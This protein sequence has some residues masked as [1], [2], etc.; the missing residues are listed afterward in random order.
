MLFVTLLCAPCHSVAEEIARAMQL[1]VIINDTPTQLIGA[2]VMRDDGRIATRRQELEEIGFNPRGYASPDQLVALDELPGLSYRYDEPTQRIFITA[3]DEL[4]ARKEYKIINKQ[5]DAA[6][7]QSD[8]GSVLNYSVFSS[9]DSRLKARSFTFNGTSATL[10][11]RAFTPF[12]TF[13]QSGI[14]RTSL[15]DRFDALRLNTSVAYSDHDSLTTYSAGDTINSGLAWTRPI[16]MGG[17]QVARN[18]GLRPDLITLPLPAAEGSAAVPSTADVYINNIKTFSQ[19]VGTGPYRLS[20]LPAVAGS[21]MARVILR[22]ASGRETETN[23]PFYASAA[24]LAPGLFDYSV[25]AG[26]PRLSYG[27]ASDRYIAKPVASGSLRYGVFDWLTL[28]A[29]VE[30]GAGL[31]NGSSGIVARTGSFGVASFAVAA[32]QYEKGTGFQTYLSYETKLLGINISASSQLTFGAYDDL[33]SV[34]AR[35][36][37]GPA[38]P[39]GLGSLLDLSASVNAAASSLFTTARAPKALNRLSLGVPLPFDRASLSATFIQTTDAVGNRSSIASLTLTAGLPYETSFF[40]TA[41]MTLAGEKN[42]GFLAG[43]SLPLGNSVTASTSVSNGPGGTSINFDAAK[44]LDLKPGSVGWRLR[45]SEGGAAQRSAAMSY[46]SSFA[47]AEIGASQDRNGA[48]VTADIEG[49][50][51]TMGGGVFFAN[52]I[53]DAFAVVET[54]APGVEVFHENRSVGVT[55]SAGRALIPGLRSYQ[56]N[57]VSIDTSTLPV[58]A[59]IATTESIVAPADR[60]GVRLNFAV[61]VNVRPAL[62]IFKDVKGEPLAAG[63][64]GQIEGGESFVV[65]YDGQAYIKNLAAENK[66]T[67]TMLSGEC[68]ASFAYTPRPN[69]QVVISPVVCR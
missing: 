36:P 45:D 31:I 47:R 29:H 14:L 30:A 25:E 49:S 53:D 64:M 5:Q 4:R 40:A 7:V 34:T 67:I 39:L 19:D 60:S 58:D 2:F 21:G 26:L 22:D 16:R 17:L 55:N 46:R 42:T 57:K 66:T 24:L 20:N 51:V 52:R 59:D 9:A 44:P 61:Q 12:G 11:A 13:S 63:S 62:V 43:I 6:P 15:N 37:S 1:E 54:G 35:L 56:P 8:Y 38:D 65:G 3:P 10:D 27:T 50:V 28:A 41:F 33:A 68:R 18:F 23:L 48:L 69:E 32:S